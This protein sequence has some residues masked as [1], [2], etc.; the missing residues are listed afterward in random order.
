MPLRRL[1]L[2]SLAVALWLSL[3]SGGTAAASFPGA[4]GL[5][6]LARSADPDESSIWVLDWQ[7]G[8]A[9]QL[10]DQGYAAEPAF[11][12]DG[13]WIVFRSDASWHGYLNI[14]AIRADGTGLHRLTLGRGN[15]SAGSP[16]FSANGRWVAF[17]AEARGGGGEIDRVVLSG[18][19]RRVLLSGTRKSSAY[20]PS[21]SPDGRHLAWVRSPE[22]LRGGGAVPHIFVGNAMG[23]RG[24][25]LTSGSEP[26]FSP[27]GRS[28]VFT[29]RRPCGSGSLGAEVA[30]VSLD[31][32][33]QS[34]VKRACGVGLYAP[35]YSPD[36]TWIAYTVFTGEK[37]EL[38]FAPTPAASPSYAPLPGLGTD[39]PVDE[40]PSWQSLR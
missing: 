15:L 31:T 38:A 11:S 9:R 6:A 39:L 27:D 33:K 29:R 3:L 8:A 20:G 21:Y 13:E 40:A 7:T 22:V 32:G 5:I 10:T 12:P 28:I 37:S 14:W 1:A 17:S 16:A 25:R 35:T 26:Q 24:R 19:H 34:P 2:A 30:T 18:G 23:R 36:G 4:P